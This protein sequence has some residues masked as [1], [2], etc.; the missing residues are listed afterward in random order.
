MQPIQSD[1][2]QDKIDIRW[3][4][5]QTQQ[6]EMQQQ[7]ITKNPNTSQRKEA[8][9]SSDPDSLWGWGWGVGRS[10]WQELINIGC[11]EIGWF[12]SRMR[13]FIVPFSAA[14]A[15][16]A[17]RQGDG[18]RPRSHACILERTINVIVSLNLAHEGEYNYSAAFSRIYMQMTVPLLICYF[19]AIPADEA[20]EGRKRKARYL[21]LPRLLVS[22]WGQRRRCG[23]FA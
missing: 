10:G 7:L 18:D 16:V 14:P 4:A 1:A 11:R 2:N 8:S 21:T 15:C 19:C 17:R 12:R 3:G 9:W 13:S 5:G 20:E 23:A 6:H 22:G